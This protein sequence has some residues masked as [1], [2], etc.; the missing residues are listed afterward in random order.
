MHGLL[1]CSFCNIFILNILCNQGNNFSNLV[2][3]LSHLFPVLVIFG[4]D[5]AFGGVF[6]CTVGLADKYGAFLMTYG[7]GSF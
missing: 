3:F 5:V 6:R 1:P 4:E 2:L 7:S